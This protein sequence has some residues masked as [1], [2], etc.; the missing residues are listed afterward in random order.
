MAGKLFYKNYADGNLAGVVKIAD[1]LTSSSAALKTGDI[2][3]STEDSGTKTPGQG[4]YDY[5]PSGE[6]P[7]YN[8]GAIKI[9]RI[10]AKPVSL[11]PTALPRLK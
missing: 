9:P 3:F 1:G 4:Y 5:K 7:E 2:S 8:T 6:K 11:M 10:S